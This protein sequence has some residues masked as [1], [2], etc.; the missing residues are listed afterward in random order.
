MRD[1]DMEN[2][3][4][5]PLRDSV[6]QTLR[7]EILRGELKPGQRLMEIHLAD[8]LGVSRT[9]VREA[10]RKL[11]QEGL[12]QMIPRRGAVVA[13]ITEEDLRDVLEVRKVLEC[14]AMELVCR[15]RTEEDLTALKQALDDFR[16][17]IRSGEQSRIAVCDVVFHE[18][19]YEMTGNQR[20]I[21]ILNSMR[22]PMYRYRME[23][24][25]E[26]EKRTM[27]VEEHLDMVSAIE[28]RDVRAAKK[29]I[30]QHISNQQASLLESLKNRD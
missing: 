1:F 30:T 9:P 23:Y 18:L 4:F 26:E 11:E 10:V 20:L 15:R 17:E 25:K 29:I 21:Q 28:N 6:F 5:L 24:L 7:D 13:N 3:E 16:R 27:L 14:L 2:R 12:V 22:G 19:I 8:R